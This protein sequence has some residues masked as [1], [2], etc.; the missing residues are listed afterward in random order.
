MTTQT[1]SGTASVEA[2]V[3]TALARRGRWHRGE[4]A[5]WGLVILAFLALPSRYLLINEIAIL[6]LFALSL[7]LVLG[8]AG[9]VSLGHAA[10]LGWGA[11]V[12]GL[13]TKHGV[14]DPTLGLVLCGASAAA[15]GFATSFVVLR[16]SDL[17]RLM[18]TLGVA[19]VLGEIANQMPSLTGGADG[20]QGVAPGPV[21]GLFGFDIFGRTACIYSLAVLLAMFLLARRIVNSPFGL[22][23]RSI[24]DNPLRAAAIG[25]PVGRRLV[26]IYTVA[27][28]YAGIAGA[29]LAQTTQFV[30]LDVFDFSRS[31][32]VLLVLIIGG[33][34][35]L[36]GGLIGAAAFRVMQ[37]GFSAITPQHWQFWIGLVLVTLVL[38]R[39]DR[40]VHAWRYGFGAIA[41]RVGIDIGRAELGK[42]E[43]GKA[44][45][46]MPSSGAS[47]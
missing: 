22:S 4:T 23:L 27:A 31:A 46:T 34:G 13:L 25:I 10:F 8:Y 12:A 24:R 29:L 38:V 11:Y 35:Y 5:F 9:I 19:L 44:K 15:L 33:T 1:G 36:Y 14:P 39:R 32:D 17:T 45:A 21:L 40:L 47:P 6:A 18:V 42:A 28:A 43:L 2:S 20:L 3:V 7:D 16:G 37:D 41:A 30:S 26:A